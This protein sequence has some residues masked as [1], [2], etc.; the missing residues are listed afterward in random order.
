[1]NIGARSLGDHWE[2]AAASDY[3]AAEL[4]ASGFELERQGF[5]VG[6]VVVQNL[7]ALVPGSDLGQE[8]IVVGAHYDTAT[9]DRGAD[10]N[11][12]GVAALLALADAFKRRTPRRKFRFVAYAPGQ[13]PHF[14]SETM[15]SLRHAKALVAEGEKVR[16][17]LSLDSLGNFATH[18]GSQRPLDGIE[19]P[20][21]AQGNFLL[22]LAVASSRAMGEELGTHLARGTGLEIAVRTLREGG[23][24]GLGSDDWAFRRVGIPAIVVS[25]TKDL[26]SR[27]G[28]DR[29]GELP[30]AEK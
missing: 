10:S 20:L 11:A 15:G 29:F 22:V 28:E 6:D 1:V 18:A 3:I 27:Q 2:L 5:D 4:E 19:E 25:D 16:L 12:T 9:D 30:G 8:S 7:G 23:A 21:P 26:R 24:Q 17:M 14:G 13:A